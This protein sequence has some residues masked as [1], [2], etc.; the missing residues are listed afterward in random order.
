MYCSNHEILTHFSVRL[1]G[2]L[3]NSLLILESE[4]L[5]VVIGRVLNLL[6]LI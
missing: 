5:L 2:T 3:M 1:D 6:E 4:G